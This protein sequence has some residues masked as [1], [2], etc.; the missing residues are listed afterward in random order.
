[1]CSITVQLDHINNNNLGKYLLN[2]Y[3]VPSFPGTQMVRE[4]A[5]NGRGLGS[6][7]AL[8]KSPGEENNNSL[9]YYCLEN[10]MD[11]GAWQPAV[12]GV[13]KIGHDL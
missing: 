8:G 1:M 12:H 6:I 13:S 10:S 7:P 9:Q 3:Y 5:C 11:K 2:A 4:S